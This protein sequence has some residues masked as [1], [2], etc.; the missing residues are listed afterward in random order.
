MKVFRFTVLFTCAVI[1]LTGIF[2]CGKKKDS[3]K[4]TIGLLLNAANPDL[5]QKDEQYFIGQAKALGAEV[6]KLTAEG[7]QESQNK[8]A[9]ELLNEGVDV[10]VVMPQN[11]KE[12]SSIVKSAREKNVPVISYR[13]VIPNSDLNLCVAFDEGKIGYIQSLGVLQSVSKGNFILLG[14]SAAVHAGQLQAIKEHEQSSGNKITILSDTFLEKGD[15]KEAHTKTTELLGKFKNVNA[16]IASTDEI[17]AGVIE[18]LKEAKLEG[19]VAVSGQDA[20]LAACQRVIEGTQVVTIF[21]SP[22]KIAPVTAEAAVRLAKGMSTDSIA[23]ALSLTLSAT[24][25]GSKLVPSLLVEPTAVTSETILN[26]IVKERIYPM[27]KV[28]T[29]VPKDKW[30]TKM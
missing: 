16:I 24:N 20:D 13:S 25:N 10:L 27:D 26:V 29:N 22:K 4:I 5:R 8:Q 14:N 17:A 23:K 6:V 3:G 9:E 18:A 2:G 21:K 28:Y 11:A 1:V 30:P 19:K 12:A 15:S 7:T